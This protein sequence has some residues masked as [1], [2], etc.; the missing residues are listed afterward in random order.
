M[1]KLLSKG[2][3]LSALAVFITGCGGGS[4]DEYEQI[5]NEGGGKDSS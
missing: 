4:S 2:M 3:L 1:K 5:P